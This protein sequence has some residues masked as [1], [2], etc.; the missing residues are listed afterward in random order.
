MMSSPITTAW[1]AIQRLA[2]HS[3]PRLTKYHEARRLLARDAVVD[4]SDDLIAALDDT[5]R[6]I[7][8]NDA[9]RLEFKSLWGVDLQPG[10]SMID[11]LRPWPEDFQNAQDLWSRALGG[12]SFTETV[13]FGPPDISRVYEL[14]FHPLYD[15]SGQR[16]GAAHIVRNVTDRFEKERRLRARERRADLLARLSDATRKLI[17]AHEICR[18]AMRLLRESLDADRCVWADV[19]ADEDHFTFIGVEVRPGVPTVTGRFS[20]SAMGLEA[21]QK[22]RSGQP[23]VCTDAHT[24]LPE[25]AERAAYVSTGVCALLATPLHKEG[26]FVAGTGAHMLSPRQWTIEEIELARAVAERC[27][28]SIDR[29]RA[30]V[31]LREADRHKDEFLSTLAHELRGPLAPLSN[32][33]A[34]LQITTDQQARNGIHEIM[35]RQLKRFA[36]LLDD[37][38]DVSQITRGQIKLERSRTELTTVVHQAVERCR[39]GQ[40][41]RQLAVNLPPH[42]IYLYADASRLTQVFAILLD[43]AYRST[44]PTGQVWLAVESAG[45][46]VT[47]RVRDDGAGIAAENIGHIFELFSQVGGRDAQGDRG[48]GIGLM[49]ARKLVELHGGTVDAHSEGNGRGSEFVVRLRAA[50]DQSNPIGAR[51][52]AK[53]DAAS[54]PRLRVLVVD[55]NRDAAWSAATL[56]A[57]WGHDV[58]LAFDGRGAIEK[59]RQQDTELMLLDLGMPEVDGYEVC[60][61]L[62]AQP[63]ADSMSIVALTGWG[64]SEDRIRTHEAGFDAHVVKPINETVLNSLLAR[65]GP[66]WSRIAR[67]RPSKQ[68]ATDPRPGNGSER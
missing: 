9:Y 24:D 11:L 63:W 20:V 51:A 38:V 34:A 14:R 2:A 30:E 15:A 21:L 6:Y 37:L 13:R 29:A 57:L 62:R 55:D 68:S 56:L 58:E 60:R 42:P 12:E 43:T 46:S 48:L 10:D 31:A 3:P 7:Y 26:H 36:T 25:G 61:T 16:L 47:V 45:T 39:A 5:F 8:F 54:I 50:P 44:T 1:R 33:L 22:M 52:D 49:Q 53:P 19:E 32:G 64:Q 35:D 59:A 17:D 23:F 27:W 18:A 41:E 40:D 66:I 67:R 4:L 65:P 28:E